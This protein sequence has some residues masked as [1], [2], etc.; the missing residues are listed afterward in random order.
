M[1][2]TVDSYQVQRLCT[3]QGPVFEQ[4]SL[5]FATLIAKFLIVGSLTVVSIKSHHISE[6]KNI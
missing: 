2:G 6:Y 5:G 3:D 4:I 1:F